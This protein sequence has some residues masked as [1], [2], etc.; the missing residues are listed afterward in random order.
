M[1][2]YK[3]TL[4]CLFLAFS[5]TLSVAQDIS[6]DTIEARIAALSEMTVRSIS[7]NF[8]VV[9]TNRAESVALGHWCKDASKQIEHITGVPIPFDNLKINVI[10]DETHQND[11]CGSIVR[12]SKSGLKHTS[13][14]YLESY[15]AA[16]ELRGRQAICCAILRG[17]LDN[18]S[19]HQFAIPDWL[20]KGIEQ[21]LLFDIRSRNMELVL[22]D[23]RVGKL[24]SVLNIIGNVDSVGTQSDPETVESA[25]TMASYSVF[26]RWLSSRSNKKTIF[27][28]LFSNAN[29]ITIVGLG[30]LV[31][32]GDSEVTLDESW[33]RWLL[34]QGRVVRRS[35]PISMRVI[36]QLRS[37]LLLYPGTYGIPLVCEIDQ[38]ESLVNLIRLREEKWVP[39]YLNRKR[40]RINL[41]VAGRKGELPKVVDLFDDFLSGLEKEIPDILL[42][43]RWRNANA[44]LN[45][46][47]EQVK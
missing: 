29:Y 40:G 24:P 27:S 15:D 19:M 41:I 26:V 12:Y 2:F 31:N 42:L 18:R 38:G 47:A 43:Q 7:G 20:W 37:E 45:R 16:Y 8:I 34:E 4:F 10:V 33:E 1:T 44:A 36:E 14:V 22:V 25:L 21:N 6:S 13:W 5:L 39:Q 28:T 11:D 9:G 32:G 30:I 46:L 23:W 35:A 17:Y 3:I